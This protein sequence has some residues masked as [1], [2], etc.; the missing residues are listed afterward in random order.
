[1]E[2]A[3]DPSLDIHETSFSIAAWVKPEQ[4]GDQVYFG[5]HGAYAPQQSLHLRIY[6]Y[7]TVRFGF[8]FDDL[9]TNSGA[10][11]FGQWNHIVCTYESASDTSTIFVNDVEQVSGDQG[12]FLGASPAI[13][14]GQWLNGLPQS[15]KGSIDEVRLYNG[16]LTESEIQELYSSSGAPG[17]LVTVDEHYVTINVADSP[18]LNYGV[19]DFSVVVEASGAGGTSWSHTAGVVRQGEEIIVYLDGAEQARQTIGT[20]AVDTL[21]IRI[22]LEGESTDTTIDEVSLFDRALSPEEIAA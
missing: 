5:M 15:F 13:S 17:E 16:A 3:Y 18:E 6:D 9:D 12:P 4:N 2:I 10:V 21:T 11:T 19:G 8:Y 1:M 14:I 20:G 22:S 7:G